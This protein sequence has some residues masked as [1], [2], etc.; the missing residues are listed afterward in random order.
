MRNC[1]LKSAVVL[2]FLAQLSTALLNEFRSL[3]GKRITRGRPTEFRRVRMYTAYVST[4][5]G[6]DLNYVEVPPLC[7]TSDAM[8]RAPI[9]ILHGLLGQS[10]NFG[11]WARDLKAKHLDFDRRVI[12]ADLRNH[13]DS[14]HAAEMAYHLMAADVLRLID[15]LEC[16]TAVLIGHSMGGKVAMASALL[17]PARYVHPTFTLELV[18]VL[19]RPSF[20]PH[21]RLKN[22]FALHP[23]RSP[24]AI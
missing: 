1:E 19:N 9:I 5:Q 16:K 24:G 22:R 21:N 12:V 15:Q 23:R 13:G 18:F 3:R 17:F 14:P 6:V 8:A 4:N 20:P 11:T 2:A 7:T 10:K